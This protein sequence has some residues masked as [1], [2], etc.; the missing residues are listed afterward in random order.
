MYGPAHP[1]SAGSSSEETGI[2]SSPNGVIF[3]HKRCFYEILPASVDHDNHTCIVTT[4]N[5][6]DA[7]D[8]ASFTQPVLLVWTAGRWW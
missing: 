7:A 3:L 6:C 1:V 4:G 5:L 2:S 8:Y